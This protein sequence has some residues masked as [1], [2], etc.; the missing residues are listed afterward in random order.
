MYWNY[1]LVRRVADING[2]EIPFLSIM[3]VYYDATDD[4]IMGWVDKE[5]TPYGEC[6]EDIKDDL[7]FI[8]QACDRPILEYDDLPKGL[9]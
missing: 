9:S 6:I 3:E 5:V 1:R 4:S 7:D 8:S 2:Y